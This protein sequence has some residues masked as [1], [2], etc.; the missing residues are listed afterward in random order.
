MLY[1]TRIVVCSIIRRYVSRT[2]IFTLYRMQVQKQYDIIR[3]R[4]SYIVLFITYSLCLY[5]ALLR[6]FR[7]LLLFNE[8]NVL[9]Y[10]RTFRPILSYES[11]QPQVL[12]RY[13]LLPIYYARYRSR[14]DIIL[15]GYDYLIQYSL[16]LTLYIYTLLCFVYFIVFCYLTNIIYYSTYVPFVRRYYTKSYSLRY[17][18]AKAI[19]KT[20]RIPH[21]LQY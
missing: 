7:S 5:V 9:Q 17:L 14:G 10:I 6:I 16:L 11:L 15:F 2:Y 13:Q 8:Y 1:R 19:Q 4:P 21:Y 3:L 12:Y 18:I 20:Y